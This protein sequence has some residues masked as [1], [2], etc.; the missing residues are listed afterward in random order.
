MALD[1]G[2]RI[3]TDPEE[4]LGSIPYAETPR[5]LIE[6]LYTNVLG[7]QPD[8]GG[9]DYWTSVLASGVPLSDIVNAF[10]QSSEFSDLAPFDANQDQNI[11]AD[12]RQ[13]YLDSLLPPVD[14]VNDIVAVSDDSISGGTST[15]SGGTST[16]PGG[17]STVPGGTST[18]SGGTSTV[19]G[20]GTFNNQID[21]SQNPPVP[22][23]LPE[24]TTL[25]ART[26]NG[27]VYPTV[28]AADA[29]RAVDTAILLGTY[30]FRGTQVGDIRDLGEPDDTLVGGTDTLVGGTDTSV[31]GGGT[32]TLVGGTDT[33]VGGGGGK[34]TS[35]V[36]GGTSTVSGGTSTVSGGTSTVSGGTSTV[37]GGTSTV[38][39]GT[40]TSTY[41]P[42][43]LS[44]LTPVTR[45]V[46]EPSDV[47]TSFQPRASAPKLAGPSATPSYLRSAADQP[48]YNM[49][50]EVLGRIPEAE[51]LAY[52]KS[53][54]GEQISPEERQAF[55]TASQQEIDN[56][57]RN[58]Y[59]DVLGRKPDPEGFAYWKTKFGD[60]IDPNELSE[61]KT[62]A[63]SELAARPSPTYKGPS[64]TYGTPG[65][66][67]PVP[68][69]LQQALA[70]GLTKDQYYANINSYLN[71]GV[72]PGQILTDMTKYG[73][74]ADDLIG[75]RGVT[76]AAT[77]ATG[78]AGSGAPPINNTPSNETPVVD[79]GK[80]G[81][82]VVR[83]AE[84]GTPMAKYDFPDFGL[85]RATPKGVFSYEKDVVFNPE[86]AKAEAIERARIAADPRE[87]ARLER[88]RLMKFGLITSP[89]QDIASQYWNDRFLSQIDY[90]NPGDKAFYESFDVD[91]NRRISPEEQ[92]AYLKAVGMREGGSTKGLGSIAMKGYAEE[93]AQKGRFGD[94]ML[95]HISPEEAQMLQA[96]G[97]AGTINPHTGLPEY[98]SW[99]KLLKG[100]GK[101]LPFVLPFT[102]IGLGAQALISGLSGAVSGEKG[103]DFKR[104]LM[105]GLMSYGMG[106]LAQGAGAA[107]TTVGADQAA[108]AALS[109]DVGRAAANN[110]DPLLRES[111]TASQVASQAGITP[112]A[113][114]TYGNIFSSDRGVL[115]QLG[116]NIQAAGQGAMG[117]ATGAPGAREA[118]TAGQGSVFGKQI[119]PTMAA[120]ATAVGMGG[121][122]AADE[123]NQFELQQ[124]MAA[125]KTEEERERYR[126]LFLRTLGQVYAGGGMTGL[127]ALAA[128]G[129]T[130]PA[131][132]PRTIN[133]A[134]DGMSD[135]VPATIEGIQEARLADGEFVIPADVVA[136]L[137][138]GSSSAGSKKLYAMMDRIRHARHGTTK[139]P[140]EIN[141]R[142]LMPA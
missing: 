87:Q 36:S 52:W 104:G 137:G 30:N 103:F 70:S 23:T 20:A 62:A 136:D 83:L 69:G 68:S 110:I 40:S 64:L 106:S 7:R 42:K 114:P 140:P 91:K 131:N 9:I 6:S 126:Q 101:I 34:G 75:A 22:G 141:M 96:A 60:I 138:N 15:V 71:A 124:A 1:R 73:I 46:Q 139:Q 94:T 57:Y 29:A 24:D 65:F 19:S 129:A 39:G 99:R 44:A 67:A 54:F 115:S 21:A 79:G 16:V 25:A 85:T 8:A 98:F 121:V 56:S 113:T 120:G 59:Q 116:E 74:T 37:P 84:G 90:A 18:V 100:V 12:E 77:P 32:D 13:R 66:N 81:G 130:G 45:K 38:S 61:F 92:R 80:A 3:F 4:D 5:G 78:N 11:S 119:S 95:A 50:Q 10:R 122:K 2:T 135:S 112:A 123:M 35:T 27:T 108:Q 127:S 134:G 48:Y 117:A 82:A 142:R 93:M 132:A 49:Y 53:Q 55:R 41:V 43:G 58:M 111:M 47:I 133:G 107:G 88:D 86:F 125:A 128:G 109:T 72:A 26:Y 63:A 97:G 17:T 89:A 102:G 14:I 31:G 33:L 51:G 28:A 105:S 118:F 76:S